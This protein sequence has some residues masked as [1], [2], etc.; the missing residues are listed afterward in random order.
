ML[1]PAL[2]VLEICNMIS[3]ETSLQIAR[4]PKQSPMTIAEDTSA[5]P[6]QTR[7]F[8][9]ILSFPLLKFAAFLL[10]MLAPAK[11]ANA[12]LPP[13]KDGTLVVL[14]T[15]GDIDNTPANDVFI[16]A[17]G[18]VV[19]DNAEKSFFFK[20]ARA[21]RYEASIPPGVYDVFVIE[22]VSEPRCRRMQV[23]PGR[24]GTWTLKLENDEVFTQR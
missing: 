1:A 15:W 24:T 4:G 17:H 21:G 18:F 19:R 20:M 5:Q 6:L 13:E 10:L 16:E 8:M 14:V 7:I 2:N 11:F 23:A 12:G 3:N 22:G 9:R